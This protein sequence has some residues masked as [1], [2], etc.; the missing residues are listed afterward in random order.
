MRLATRGVHRGMAFSCRLALCYYFQHNIHCRW[1]LPIFGK[2]LSVILFGSR[3]PKKVYVQFI[4]VLIKNKKLLKS[5][6]KIKLR[7]CQPRHAWV[8][9]FITL[10]VQ[11]IYKFTVGLINLCKI[12]GWNSFLLVFFESWICCR[13]LVIYHSCD[14]LILYSIFCV[15]IG[16]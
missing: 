4:D 2:I 11:F 16:S 3:K 7:H 10:V 6:N 5:K 15:G 8:E 14:S 12:K 9:S 13:V 1:V